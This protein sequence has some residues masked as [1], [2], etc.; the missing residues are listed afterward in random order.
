MPLQLTT[1][2]STGDLDP[3]ASQYA[4]VKII[5]QRHNPIAGHFELV[6]H[7]GNDDGSGNWTS[8]I[9]P[10]ELHV[11]KGSIYVSLVS[12]EGDGTMTT[13]KKG[14][15]LLYEALVSEGLYD[16]TYVDTN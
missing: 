15:K 7:Y 14:A 5:R 16:G 3:D 6:C 4:W 10:S 2:K 9:L 13:Y 8:G 12:A 11:L 1:P